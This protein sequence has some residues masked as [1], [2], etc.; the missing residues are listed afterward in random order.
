MRALP[1]FL[2]LL[3]ALCAAAQTPP[4]DTAK[5]PIRIEGKAINA[6]DGTP[7]RNVEIALFGE[8]MKAAKSGADGRFSIDITPGTYRV[9]IQRAGFVLRRRP[10]TE[11]TNGAMLQLK[12]GDKIADVTIPLWPAAVIRGKV[13][14]ASGEPVSGAMVTVQNPNRLRGRG[15]MRWGI[16]GRPGMTDDNG[17]FRLFG[18]DP[19]KYVV[20]ATP[21]GAL[22]GMIDESETDPAKD[23]RTV[24]TYYPGVAD[25]RQ[26]TPITLKSG[27]EL[28][29][30]IV[31]TTARTVHVKGKVMG[32]KTAAAVMMMSD[33]FSF[34]GRAE[35]KD[36]KFDIGGVAPGRYM[37]QAV[38]FEPDEDPQTTSQR[39]EVGPAGLND[40]V[41]T[42]G[43]ATVT[44]TVSAEGGKLDPK[45]LEL[46]LA[47]A[48]IIEFGSGGGFAFTNGRDDNGR[49]NENGVAE[50]KNLSPG[51]YYLMVAAKTTGLEDWYTK[52]VRMGTQDVTNSAIDIAP[53]AHASLT[54]VMSVD[55]ASIEGVTLDDKDKKWTNATVVA[56]PDAKRRQNREAYG[57]ATSDQNGHFKMRGL[58]PGEY[59]LFAFEEPEWA[60]DLHD[61]NRLKT[62]EASGSL[63]KLEER[64]HK[65]V[66]L[67]VIPA[68]E[69]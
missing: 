39:V 2:L 8:G 45:K 46:F 69:D 57:H 19:G 4:T 64:A 62:V 3:F 27:D 26:A 50:F 68:A 44:A 49:I 63:V 10:R 17:D 12:E 28:P 66:Q 7:L 60:E 6:V 37:L 23:V 67:K 61:A 40:I 34:G 55:G 21:A 42:F 14:D 51:R 48:D 59:T 43:R 5:E 47:E 41:L 25:Q 13:L 32:A 18:L 52:S 54:V 1:R 29:L 15:S 38:T 24:P 20:V 16:G 36:G 53:G 31:L 58:A 33:N 22:G 56:V 11:L 30:N 35:V 65:S 9:S